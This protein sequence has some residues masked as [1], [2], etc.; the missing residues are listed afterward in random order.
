MG[1]EGCYFEMC[2]CFPHLDR[3]LAL[4]SLFPPEMAGDGEIGEAVF[5]FGAAADVVDDEGA[6]VG[7]FFITDDHDVWEV[8]RNG[9]GYDIAWEVGGVFVGFWEWQGGVIAFEKG[10]QVGNTA[11]ID[12]SVCIFQ[13]PDFWVF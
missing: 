9:A 11:V 1:L 7:G 5:F 4:M 2:G 3:S 12:V 8:R 6:A 13:S 10:H